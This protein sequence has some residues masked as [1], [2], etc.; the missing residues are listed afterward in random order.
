MIDPINPYRR[1]PADY[2]ESYD[3]VVSCTVPDRALTIEEI[4]Q[5]FAVGAS[6]DNVTRHMEYDTPEGED[7][8]FDDWNVDPLTDPEK[9]D[10]SYVHDELQEIQER[11]ESYQA[12]KVPDDGSDTAPSSDSS[13]ES[14]KSDIQQS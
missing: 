4:Y 10:I 14:P 5:R 8:N 7:H 9:Q 11:I 13:D 12:V 3:G 1:N 2:S 6:L